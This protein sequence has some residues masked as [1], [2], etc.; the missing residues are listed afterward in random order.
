[1]YEIRRADLEGQAV[2]ECAKSAQS[3]ERYNG[4]ESK[5]LF[6]SSGNIPMEIKV[7]VF[8]FTSL[9]RFPA[10]SSGSSGTDT[11]GRL[12]PILLFIICVAIFNFSR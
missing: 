4:C 6:N 3:N 2:G 12:S 7:T 10:S 9:F 8:M 5:R 11:L 1:M